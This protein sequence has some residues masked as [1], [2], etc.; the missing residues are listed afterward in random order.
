MGVYFCL[1]LNC[2][3]L[4]PGLGFFFFLKQVVWIAA[5]GRDFVDNRCVQ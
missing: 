1:Q 2:K 3:Y 5:H 4:E